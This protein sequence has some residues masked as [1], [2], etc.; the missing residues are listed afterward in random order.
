MIHNLHNQQDIVSV[1]SVMSLNSDT[2]R[3]FSQAM[4]ERGLKDIHFKVKPNQTAKV[5]V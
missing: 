2:N 4:L 3:P 1:L 5:Q